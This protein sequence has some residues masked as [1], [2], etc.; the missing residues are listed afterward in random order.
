MYTFKTSV[1]VK[2]SLKEL[3]Q[4]CSHHLHMK[5]CYSF[6]NLHY[7]IFCHFDRWKI[8][9][10]GFNLY[11]LITSEHVFMLFLN[12]KLF[13]SHITCLYTLCIFLLFIFLLFIYSY[14]Y[15]YILILFSFLCYKFVLLVTYYLI[16]KFFYCDIFYL[17]CILIYYSFQ[18]LL[19]NLLSF[20]L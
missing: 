18:I 6:V 12:I 11:F 13:S 14:L 1:T 4:F 17:R 9:S 7:F 2:S 3:C 16:L 5:S 10:C 19:S 8:L 20:P 15:F